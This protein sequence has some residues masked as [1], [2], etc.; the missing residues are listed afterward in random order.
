MS[1]A[2]K[3]TKG[4]KATTK[5]MLGRMER[6]KEGELHYLGMEMKEKGEHCFIVV[7]GIRGDQNSLPC[8]IRGRRFDCTITTLLLES[9]IFS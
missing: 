3:N 6:R 7:F 9:E 2:V 8:L 1:K 4:M 5:T